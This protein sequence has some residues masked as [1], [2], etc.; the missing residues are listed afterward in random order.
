MRP[1]AKESMAKRRLSFRRM[2]RDWGDIDGQI[3]F[4]FVFIVGGGVMGF[5]VRSTSASSSDESRLSASTV[6]SWTTC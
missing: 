6:S 4:L 3:D 1:E 2:R 5:L